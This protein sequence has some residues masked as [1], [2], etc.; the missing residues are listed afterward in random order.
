MTFL[1]CSTKPTLINEVRQDVL[2]L[3][4]ILGK[5]DMKTR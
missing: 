2:H 5:P 3:D 1:T 4:H